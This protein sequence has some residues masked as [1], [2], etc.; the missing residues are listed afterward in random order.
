MSEEKRSAE[1][2]AMED[3]ITGG[4][5]ITRHSCDGTVEHIPADQFLES[6][7]EGQF[8]RAE[9]ASLHRS[10]QKAAEPFVRRLA[11][12]EACKPP[13]PIMIRWDDLDPE[14]QRRILKNTGA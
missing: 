6:M 11:A 3:A 2:R 9:L 13:P 8:L 4:L 10:Y 12:I 14:M 7:T 5:G 1:S